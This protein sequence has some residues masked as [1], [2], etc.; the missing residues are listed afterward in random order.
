MRLESG[1]LKHLR[2]RE[3]FAYKT[4]CSEIFAFSQHSAKGQSTE[5]IAYNTLESQIVCL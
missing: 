3:K 1:C 4:L 2:F 5:L